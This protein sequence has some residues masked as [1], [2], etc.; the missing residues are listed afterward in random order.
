[1]L[2]S[3]KALK[4]LHNNNG[5]TVHYTPK[6]ITSTRIL[7]YSYIPPFIFFHIMILFEFSVYRKPDKLKI[8]S[9]TFCMHTN[10]HS[11]M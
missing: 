9:I 3:V 11:I 10:I 4:P 8:Y 1:M 5:D 6:G 7:L 2:V